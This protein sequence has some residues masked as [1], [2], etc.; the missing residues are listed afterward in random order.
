MKP[1]LLVSNELNQQC[2]TVVFTLIVKAGQQ[3]RDSYIN[4]Y[5]SIIEMRDFLVDFKEKSVH[6]H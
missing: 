4:I 1:L 3:L 2:P 5:V 6:K